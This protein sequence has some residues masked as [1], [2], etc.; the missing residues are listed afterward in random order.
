MLDD[1]LESTS[2]LCT[3]LIA[4]LLVLSPDRSLYGDVQVHRNANNFGVQFV[5]LINRQSFQRCGGQGDDDLLD[6]TLAGRII[7]MESAAAQQ[8]H[9]SSVLFPRDL[10]VLAEVLVREIRDNGAS[11]PRSKSYRGLL[12][13]I[14]TSSLKPV[15]CHVD[16]SEYM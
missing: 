12:N 13:T 7:E 5:S 4:M 2:S 16:F 11:S 15:E 9:P 3:H 14:A 8:A 6:V 1:A 10:A